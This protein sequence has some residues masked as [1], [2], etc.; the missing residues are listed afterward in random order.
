M[1]DALKAY[2][3]LYAARY[4]Q[5]ALSVM[6]E[7]KRKDFWEMQAH[8]AV[9][10]WLICISYV[11]GWN[12]VG[13]VVMVLLDPADVP[14][15]LAKMVKYIGDTRGGGAQKRCQLAADI[16][17]VVFMLSFLVMRLILYPYVCWSA[18]FEAA[19]Y[20]SYD[21]GAWACVV[22][23]YVLLALQFYWF[24]LIVK[25]AVKVLT[26][27]AAEDVRSDDEEEEE[28]GEAAP[29]SGRP[30]GKKRK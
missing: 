20:F 30:E 13:A 22:L 10:V 1:S 4:I 11:Y 26:S 3:L 29:A 21:S 2:Y 9:T 8:H 5:G 25:V 15:H 19:R 28:E 12:R 14:L 6:M 27:G 7:H 23:L 24:A 18:H 16:L 17:F